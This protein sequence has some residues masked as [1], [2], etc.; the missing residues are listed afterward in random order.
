MTTLQPVDA[1]KQASPKEEEEGRKEE[2]EQWRRW[3]EQ[4]RSLQNL[5][6]F[7]LLLPSLLAGCNN[8]DARKLSPFHFGAVDTMMVIRMRRRLL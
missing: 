5:V 6:C 8:N 7:L 2:E 1:C 3:I 4:P